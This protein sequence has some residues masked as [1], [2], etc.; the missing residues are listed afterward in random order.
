MRSVEL[1]WL[2]MIEWIELGKIQRNNVWKSKTEVISRKN[3]SNKQIPW[4]PEQRRR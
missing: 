1:N 4:R 3:Q 2:K